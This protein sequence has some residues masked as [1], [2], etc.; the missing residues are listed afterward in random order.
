MHESA[1]GVDR[2]AFLAALEEALLSPPWNEKLAQLVDEAAKE[3]LARFYERLVLT[4]AQINL[5]AITDPREVAVK[6][7]IDSLSAL[8]AGAWPPSAS[9]CDVGTGAGIPGLILAVVRPDLRV[10][11]VDSVA[12]KLAFAAETGRDLGLDIETLHARAEEAGRDRAHREAYDVVT[13]RAVAKMAVLSE[14]ALPLV[15][16]GGWFIALKGP[17]ADEELREG[18]AA[19]RKLGGGDPIVHRVTLP[20]GFGDRTLIAIP[21]H[22]PT[23]GGYPRRAGLPSKRPLM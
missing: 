9:V 12:K 19:V 7:V 3:R 17:G 22:K 1:P 16:V 10:V 21:K 23:P 4:N 11:L 6:H 8:F 13:A 20:G 14:Y 2:K 5:T 18:L 15:R